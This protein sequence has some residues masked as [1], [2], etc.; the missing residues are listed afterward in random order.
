DSVFAS[1]VASDVLLFLRAALH[2]DNDRA[3]RTAAASSLFDLS[4]FD[5]ER[6]NQ[7]EQYWELLSQEF[8]DYRQ[9][10]LKAGIMPMIRRLIQYREL[11][12]RLQNEHQ[13]ER[14]LTDLMHLAEL[15]QQASAELESD[16]A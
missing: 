13:G 15:L 5:L 3:L 14:V 6:L 4:L 12:Q 16:H 8:S 9:L 7:D 11:A 1:P 2:F 10:W